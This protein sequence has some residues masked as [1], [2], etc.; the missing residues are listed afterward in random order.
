MASWLANRVRKPN[1]LRIILQVAL[2]SMLAFCGRIQHTEHCQACTPFAGEPH[3][4]ACHSSRVPLERIPASTHSGQ[5]ERAACLVQTTAPRAVAQVEVKAP[6][7]RA[8]KP[9]LYAASWPYE[10]RIVAA[11][12]GSNQL[13]A[14]P[15]S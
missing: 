3:V 15:A 2:L 13:R 9:I 4:C 5:S 11:P 7:I 6:E 14:P 10:Q 1:A 8:F 12:I